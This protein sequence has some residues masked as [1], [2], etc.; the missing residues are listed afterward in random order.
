M[1]RFRLALL[2]LLLPLCAACAPKVTMT[3][4]PEAPYPPPRPPAVGDILHLPTGLFVSEGQ[5][6]SVATDARIVYVGE[7]HDNPASH[8]LQVAVLRAMAERWPGR[9]A[10]G[11]EMFTPAQQPALD[12]WV[13]GESTEKEFLKESRWYDRWK[14]DFDYY[15][16]LLLF[17]REQRIPVVGLNAEKGLV[18]AV[19][20]SEPAALDEAERAQLP[21]MDLS[22]PYQRSL[23]KAIFGGHD[24][25]SGQL[26]GF[27]RAQT[28]WDETMA[29]NVAAHLSA[30]GNE[31]RRMVVVAGGNH[32]RNGFGIPRRVFRRLPASYLLLGT[33]ELEIAPDMQDRLMDVQIPDYPMP[34]YDFVAFTAYERLQKE[35][36]RLGVLLGEA[37][38]AVKVQGVQPGSAAAAAGVR[39]GDEVRAIDGQPVAETFDLVYQVRQHKPGDRVTLQLERGGEMLSVE[40]EFASA[41]REP[42][43]EHPRRK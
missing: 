29:Q 19:T 25:G 28:L 4:N 18:R 3:G 11:M 20:R 5:M 17:A 33:K 21:E 30:P 27:L 7:T 6:L 14:M 2:A 8:R 12:R 42:P 36:V 1:H 22:D 23:V 32:V 13:A 37:D 34:A 39:E 9:V 31:E 15:R 43:A 16:E 40:V 41:A 38:G 35:E 10:L 26:D 24:G